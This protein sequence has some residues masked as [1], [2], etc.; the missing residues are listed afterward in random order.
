[1]PRGIRGSG[2]KSQ[3]QGHNWTPAQR[4]KAQRALQTLTTL[5]GTAGRSNT[6]RGTGMGRTQ[7][8]RT[9]TGTRQRRAATA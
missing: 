9:T 6:A 3:G 1:M 2:Q 8:K 4:L 7:A 5:M